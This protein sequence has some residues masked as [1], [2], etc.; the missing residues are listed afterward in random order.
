MANLNIVYSATASNPGTGA[1]LIGLNGDSLFLTTKTLQITCDAAGYVTS[2]N[3]G[4]VMP[5]WEQVLCTDIKLNGTLAANRAAF[6]AGM[7]ILFCG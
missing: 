6:I 1:Q 7:M 5:E 3:R 4:V 2:K